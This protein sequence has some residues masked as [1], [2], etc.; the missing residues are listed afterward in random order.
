M[1]TGVEA[2]GA[3]FLPSPMSEYHGGPEALG[4]PATWHAVWL[5]PGRRCQLIRRGGAA[6]LW[7][8]DLVRISNKADGVVGAAMELPD[9][10]VVDGFLRDDTTAPGFAGFDLLEHEG[11]DIRGLPHGVRYG[12]LAE[13]LPCGHALLRRPER[14]SCATPEELSLLLRE[15]RARGFNGILMATDRVPVGGGAPFAWLILKPEPLMLDAALL[16]VESG[17]TWTFGVR[18][19]ERWLAVARVDAHLSDTEMHETDAFV[20]ANTLERFGPVRTVPPVLIFTLAFDG[21]RAAPR[22]RSG[23]TLVNPVLRARRRDADTAAAAT[24]EDLRRLHDAPEHCA[25]AP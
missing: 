25:G 16:Y 18:D 4:T 9:G 23:F 11:R 7:T 3:P 17:G 20:R 15:A 19:G 12:R 14:L 2:P 10:T 22:R 21:V 8:D 24:L 6:S 5:P 13:V 1:K